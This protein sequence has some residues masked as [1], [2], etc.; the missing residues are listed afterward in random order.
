VWFALRVPIHVDPA[1]VYRP[2][3]EIS[4]SQNPS[5]T[6]GKVSGTFLREEFDAL[7]HDLQRPALLA[8]SGD[9]L[10]LPQMARDED[11]VFAAEVSDTEFVRFLIP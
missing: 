3:S 9:V 2:K 1:L 4:L 11:P 8:F 6:N 5:L 7:C 10:T